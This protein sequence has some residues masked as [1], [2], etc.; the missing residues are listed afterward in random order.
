[1]KTKYNIHPNITIEGIINKPKMVF[2]SDIEDDTLCQIVRKFDECAQT[3]QTIIPLIVDS[4]G[5]SMWKS[6]GIV[7]FIR[8]YDL[9]VATI[10]VSHAL[11]GGSLIH[12]SGTKGHRYVSES[13]TYMIHEQNG[14]EW[15]KHTDM[16]SRIEF[17]DFQR[18][19]LMRMYADNSDLSVA[20]LEKI[21]SERKN[22]DWYFGADECI[23]YGFADHI[24]IPTFEV[25]VSQKTSLSLGK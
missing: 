1:M 23:E 18:G 20:K 7:D 8:S 2:L 5:G 17:S 4:H 10:C 11:S 6:F 19:K 13:V 3:G 12:S 25:E 21:I 15:G 24:G 9:P 14:F 16:K 22:S